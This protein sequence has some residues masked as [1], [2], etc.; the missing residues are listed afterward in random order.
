M[1]DKMKRAKNLVG[2]ARRAGTL[3]IGLRA[4]MKSLNKKRC[5]AVLLSNDASP[6][7]L[8][9]VIRC[10]EGVAVLPVEDMQLLGAWLGG[11]PTAVV[12]ILDKNFASALVEILHGSTKGNTL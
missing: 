5:K 11:S 9:N 8:K 12:G 3:S 6:R 2:L 7:T 4:T 10:A 1:V